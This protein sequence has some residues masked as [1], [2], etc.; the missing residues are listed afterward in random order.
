M[1]I[2]SRGGAA[3]L[4]LGALIAGGCGGSSHPAAHRANAFS[5]LRD[6]GPPAG[7]RVVSIPGAAA[8]AIPPTW[9]RIRGDR[10]TATAALMGHRGAFLGYLNVT[11]QQGDER[12][13]NFAS[14]RVEH[15]AEEGDRGVRE[16]AATTAHRAGD[17]SYSCVK[18]SYTT[19]IGARFIEFACLVAGSRTSVVVVG[20]GS[21][22]SWSRVSPL[23]ERAIDGVTT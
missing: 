5:W 6:A 19:T 3:L 21:P 7:W 9:E 13:S 10:G 22:A 14:F 11:P 4:A 2:S 20:A 18:D 16:L 17:Q 23:L 1:G 12:L 8:F 15:N